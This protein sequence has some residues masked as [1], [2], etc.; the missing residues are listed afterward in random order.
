MKKRSKGVIFFG[1]LSSLIGA[2]LL[3]SYFGGGFSLFDLDSF[4][5]LRLTATIGF[6]LS[7]LF[8]LNLKNWARILFLVLMGVN[9]F[10]GLYGTY[11]G[12][13]LTV[14]P[15]SG[16]GFLNVYFPTFLIGSF[17]PFMISIYFFTRPKVK[18]Q[19]R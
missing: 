5:L 10:G 16:N 6:I 15:V 19:F 8:I 4:N 11:F 12:F 13:P 14:V 18:E 7:G 3:A 2:M 9:M 1:V 17:L